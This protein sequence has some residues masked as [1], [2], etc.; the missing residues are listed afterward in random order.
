MPLRGSTPAE[1]DAVIDTFLPLI[2]GH[3]N[4]PLANA[5]QTTFETASAAFAQQLMAFPRTFF[6]LPLGFR[7]KLP[8]RF[9]VR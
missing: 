9:V 7:T 8:G 5:P 1:I 2:A 3:P 4:D 6:L